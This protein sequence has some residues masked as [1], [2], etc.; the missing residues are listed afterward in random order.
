MSVVLLIL[1]L[2]LFAGAIV[3]LFVREVLAPAASFL[4]LTAVYFSGLLPLSPNMVITW[5]ALTVIV[6]GV[7][8]MQPA[9]LM[10]QRRG[11]GYMLGGALAGMAV[12][13]MAVSQS[14]SHEVSHAVL[15]VPLTVWYASLV[16]GAL[17]G[18]FLSFLL[19]TRSPGGRDVGMSSGRFFTYV[20]AKGFPLAIAMIQPGLVLMLWLLT[21]G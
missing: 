3:L 12:G 15:T 20:A 14:V 7:S 10:A 2:L 5:L 19:Y 13:V 9:A 18:I 1:A 6:M 17:I 8:Y 21:R 4:G 16:A 11:V